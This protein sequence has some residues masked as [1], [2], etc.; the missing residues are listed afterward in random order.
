MWGE[1]TIRIK[2]WH[3]SYLVQV[4]YATLACTKAFYPAAAPNPR[5]TSEDRLENVPLAINL[6]NLDQ[7][8]PADPHQHLHLRA[9]SPFVPIPTTRE[10]CERKA[11]SERVALE[12]SH[13]IVF[14]YG[15][16]F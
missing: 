10:A 9:L 8:R 13:G 3:E 16:R 11:S 2:S 6:P 1:C 14:L 7:Q 15:G 4:L 12:L 5:Y